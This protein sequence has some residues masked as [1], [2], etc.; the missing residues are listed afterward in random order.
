MTRFLRHGLY[1]LLLLVTLA[2]LAFELHQPPAQLGH[3]YPV[4][5][6]AMVL[7]LAVTEARWPLRREWRMTR[8]TWWR[9][10]LPFLVLGGMTLGLLQGLALHVVATGHIVR[11]TWLAELPLVPGVLVA[12][13][14]GDLLWYTLHRFSHEARGPLGRWLWRV[15]AAHHLP[16]QVYVLMHAVAHPIN[17]A[18]VRVLLT[19]PPFLL[20]LSPDAVFAAAVI[21]GFQG[22]VSHWNFDSRAGWLNNVLV[23]TELHRLHHSADPTEAGN[24]G[25][26]TSLWDRCFGT[27]V[28]PC[29]QPPSALGVTAPHEY[30]ADTDLPALLRWP[31]R[32][33]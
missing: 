9:R 13:L 15:H 1:P 32:R 27:H 4:Y 3:R 19:V 20:G 16:G 31:L 18:M 28:A 5:L 11:G 17:T 14:L 26:V 30:P 22:L 29:D 33:R 24:Y 8:A 12:L 6:G 23:G 25:A 21:T 2:Y 10:D 7:L